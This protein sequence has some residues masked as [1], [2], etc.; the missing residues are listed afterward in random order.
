VAD[1]SDV[2]L[3][4]RGDRVAT[5]DG[6]RPA[7]VAVREGR[8]VALGDRDAGPSADRVVELAADEVL[9]PGLV[10]THV[11]V[12][13]PG[14]TNW[15]GFATATRAAAAGGVTTLVDMPLNSI[16][17]TTD[18]AALDEKQAAAR[19]QLVVDVG[20]WGG[21]VPGSLGRLSALWD[22]GVYGFKCFLVPS[23][24]DEFPPLDAD[25]LDRAMAE[26]AEFEGLLIV[27]A[28]D[29]AT[30]AAAPA[31][32]GDRYADFLASRPAA[33]E[34]RA[35]AA[36]IDRAAVHGTRVHV[37]HLSS[38]GS[39]DQI[40]QARAAGI[41]VTVETCPHYLTIDAAGIGT[42]QTP[43][44]CCPP[45]RDAA[46]RDRLWSAL[47]DGTIDCVVSD[48]SPSPPELKALDRG[49]FGAA[50]GGISSLQLGLALVWSD[51]RRRG[52]DLADVIRWMATRTAEVAGILGKGRVAPGYDADFSV[53]APDETFT[54]DP[55]RLQHRHPVTPYAGRR[56]SGVVRSTWLRGAPVQA[57]RPAGRIITREEPADA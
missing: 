46:N 14:R 43:F 36:V 38:A 12:N 23:G 1:V 30:I 54:V 11:H 13:E 27:H 19:G 50:W 44:K 8:I 32:G 24:V 34:D 15:E 57:D 53:F 3:L 20:F 42:G 45:I 10:D 40:A 2:D 18:P 35:I 22:R 5:D 52:H 29:A 9:L 21:A 16:P 4:F 51:G 39:L 33:A 28:E 37:L 31:A 56:L 7:S 55:S 6:I 47:R 48:H 26:V 49:D 17:P 25:Q 41:R